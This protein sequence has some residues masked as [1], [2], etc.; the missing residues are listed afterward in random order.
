MKDKVEVLIIGAGAS[1]AAA[2]WSLTE[3]KMR[4][5]CLEQGNWM[6]QSEY[7]ANRRDFE[8]RAFSDYA[9]SPNIWKAPADCPINDENSPIKVVNFNAVGG[10]TIIGA[11][12]RNC[13]LR[14][15]EG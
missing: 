3:T 12:A 2:A 7:P 9:T 5:L 6:E 15:T 10:S 4:I 11:S 1:G 13:R 14:A 8:A